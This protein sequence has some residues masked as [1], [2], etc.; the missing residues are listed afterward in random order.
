MNRLKFHHISNLWRHLSGGASFE[1]KGAAQAA[2][3]RADPPRIRFWME[4]SLAENPWV[5]I[6]LLWVA[7][8]IA[9]CSEAPVQTTGNTVEETP[10]TA[11]S[12]APSPEAPGPS[13]FTGPWFEDRAGE[14]GLDF[15]HFNGMTGERLFSEMM[16][17]GVAFLDFDNDGDLDVYAVQ[18]RMVDAGKDPSSAVFPPPDPPWIDRLFRNDLGP[19]GP[20]FVDVTAQAGLVADGYGMGVAVGDVDNDGFPDLYV[21]N[22][23][24]DQLWMNRGDGTFEER[25]NPE[26]Q[27]DGWSVSGAFF[28]YD[29]DGFLDL[30]VVYYVDFSVEKAK[31]CKSLTGM[32]D[33]CGPLS[34]T[35]VVDRLYRNRGDGTFEDVSK[36]VGLTAPAAGLGVVVL[37]FDDDGR[38]DLAVANDGMPNHLWQNRA[39]SD[40][41]IRFD[42]V[43]VLTGMSVNQEGQAEAGMGIVAADPDGDGDEDLLLTHLALETHTFYG[44][45]GRGGFLDRSQ[46]SGLGAPSWNFTGFGVAFLDA[47]LDGLLDVA[48]VAGGVKIIP[49][50]LDAG[51]LYPLKMAK[52]LYRNNGDRFEP[53]EASKAGEPFARQR[54]GR[55]LAVGDVDNDGDSDLL[56]SNNSGPLELLINRRIDGASKHPWVGIRLVEH[57]RDALGASV[58]SP[59]RARVGTDGSYASAKDP[60]LLLSPNALDAEELSAAILTV[61]WVDGHEESFDGL[62][63]G[64]YNVLRRNQGRSVGGA[65]Q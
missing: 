24:P 49:E 9:A 51:E 16:G 26:L 12:S 10:G 58:I 8:G 1:R 28:D 23:G 45:D 2:G 35:P 29:Q 21:M 59:I 50:Q 18:G 32:I 54:V 7:L 63:P 15:Q 52:Q 57:G 14:L 40:G 62:E 46:P 41:T 27:A 30:F 55:G 43:A 38:L 20:R 61:R 13:D 47:D 65:G 60:R 44:N 37:D 6:G 4:S 17:S 48:A 36:K 11:G 34:H 53:M 42:E 33:Y 39:R 19:G 25:K 5:A 64:R 31:P 56:V 22:D 3:R